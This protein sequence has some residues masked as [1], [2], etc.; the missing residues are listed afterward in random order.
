M[1]ARL[2][3]DDLA[4]RPQ[5]HPVAVRQASALTPRD[6]LGIVL[7]E[8]TELVDEA[9]L[10]D[11]GHADERHELRRSRAAHAVERVAEDGELVLAADELRARLVLDIDPGA[12]PHLIG[13]PDRDRLGLPLGLDR[14]RLAELDRVAGRPLRRLVDE[15]AVDRRGALQASGGIDDVA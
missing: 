11:A 1:D 10:A 14:G 7:H 2:R 12:C 15:H 5:R 9:T 13:Q 3:L 6:E 4:E 8:L